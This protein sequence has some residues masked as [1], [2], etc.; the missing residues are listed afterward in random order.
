MIYAGQPWFPQRV[1]CY[2]IV[3]RLQLLSFKTNVK[4]MQ[5]QSFVR[6]RK[7]SLVKRKKYIKNARRHAK[8]VM[9]N[10]RN[11]KIRSLKNFVA[12]IVRN[13]TR[14]I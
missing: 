8:N 9:A 7:R 10:L 11:A 2:Y 13:V 1:Y 12:R 3:I 14:R 6:N 5:L 4:M